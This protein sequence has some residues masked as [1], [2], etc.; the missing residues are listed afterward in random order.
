MNH[1][2]QIELYEENNHD[3]YAN[4]NMNDHILIN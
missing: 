4:P 1:K 3:I 2:T